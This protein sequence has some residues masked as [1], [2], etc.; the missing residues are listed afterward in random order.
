MTGSTE[1]GL[2]E[3]Q[4]LPQTLLPWR[5]LPFPAP[6]DEIFG[7]RSP[8]HLEI[9]FGDGRYTARRALANPEE[10]FVGLEISTAS[11]MRAVRRMKRDGARNVRLLKVGAQFAV[12]HL[13]EPASLSSITVNFP[14]PWPKERH[15]KNRLLNRRFLRLAASRLCTGGELLLATDHPDYLE[16]S[17]SEARQTGLF[18]LEARDPPAAVFETKYALKWREQG[19][20]LYYQAFLLR[21]GPVPEF[22]ILERPAQMPHALL[23]GTPPVE[24]QFSKRALEYGDGHVILHEVVR[25]LSSELPERLLVRVTVDEPDLKQQ[26]LVAVQRRDGGELIVR[27]EPFGDPIITK[28]ARGAVHGVTEWLLEQ[29]GVRVLERNY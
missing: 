18:D 17:R 20:P 16:F 6:W 24:P 22:P 13:F 10:R 4:A 21:P 3:V 11:V 19:K 29:P 8:L 1:A 27:L 15:E 28:T 25:S 7:S 5:R 23:T 12:R 9:G 26:L 2:P 14:D